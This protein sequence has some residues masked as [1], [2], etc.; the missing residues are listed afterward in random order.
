MAVK[1]AVATGLWS[2]GATWNG[3]TLPTTGDDV[4]SNAFTVTVD[5]A[6]TV[7]TLRNTS[8]ASPAITAG[9]G[10]VA[11]NGNNI[12]ATGTTVGSFNWGLIHGSTTP[13]ITASSTVG[14]SITANFGPTQGTA[15]STGTVLC[16]GTGTINIVGNLNTSTT[17]SSYG[18]FTT[19]ACT[20]N[21]TGNITGTTGA[22]ANIPVFINSAATLSVTGNVQGATNS[23]AIL[24]GGAATATITGN[25]TAG[26]TSAIGSSNVVTIN[27]IGSVTG[28]TGVPA[29]VANTNNSVVTV[30]GPIVNRNNIMAIQCLRIKI[31]ASAVTSWT[32]QNESGTSK[33]LYTADSVLG[34]PAVTDVRS[35]VVYAS[36]ALTGTCNVPPALSVAYGVPVDNT[37][38]LSII[39]RAQLITDVGAI[40]A[41]YTV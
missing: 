17:A 16:S 30:T 40:V 12:T 7:Q 15:T 41:G 2:A 21:I 29:I 32:F 27:V 26:D 35:G 38:G 28:S 23:N 18:V 6:I 19:G 11:T 14:L 20:L 33:I 37:T 10:F 36:G 31:Y 4:Y 5:Q 13:L 24:M 34:Q 3:G 8:N 25:V 9:G 39:T 1:Y 22:S